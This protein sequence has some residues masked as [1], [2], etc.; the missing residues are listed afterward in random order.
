MQVRLPS[1]QSE[2]R[3]PKVSVIF[4]CSEVGSRTFVLLFVPM[5]ICARCAGGSASLGS[6]YVEGRVGTLCISVT[7]DPGGPLVFYSS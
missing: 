4:L 3:D 1:I 5:R 2:V 6:G 7:R